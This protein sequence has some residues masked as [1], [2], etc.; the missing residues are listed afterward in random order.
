MAGT[1]SVE[2]LVG[3]ASETREAHM[4]RHDGGH[5]SC[6][7]C[8]FYTH[9]L[10]WA[11]TYGSTECTAAGPQRSNSVAGRTAQRVG[12]RLGTRLQIVHGQ[13]G[14]SSSLCFITG[15][16]WLST[17]PAMH[18]HVQ[19]GEIRGSLLV[20]ASRARQA[21]WSY[22]LPQGCRP[23][24][25]STR[26]TGNSLVAAGLRG[27][28]IVIRSGSTATGCASSLVRS[29]RVGF[30]ESSRPHSQDGAFHREHPGQA[31]AAQELPADAFDHAGSHSRTQATV[32]PR[33]LVD[34]DVFR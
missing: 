19:V 26:R 24:I 22:L 11:S 18:L 17:P 12:W 32:D 10:T 28:R 13:R 7:R 20:N 3:P 27:R 5:K 29:T 4:S 15:R 30:V 25:S 33:L 16:G 23:C 31:R 21:T 34:F 2:E 6:P 9:G 1:S 8:T 14:S